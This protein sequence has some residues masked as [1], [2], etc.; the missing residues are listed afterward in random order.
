M[1]SVPLSQIIFRGL[2]LCSQSSD[3]KRATWRPLIDTATS[4][5]TISREKSS[6]TF[7]TRKRR[8]LARALSRNLLALWCVLLI[9]CAF[10]HIQVASAH[11]HDDT[12]VAAYS[13]HAHA[14]HETGTA[15]TC[16]AVQ[17]APFNQQLLTLLALT[18][19]LALAGSLGLLSDLQRRISSLQVIPLFRPGLPPPIRKQLHRYN[20]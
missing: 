9:A 14:T 16:S 12:G 1:N 2:P 6:T 17:N 13:S 11:A 18:A 10:A 19:L 8:P 15:E 4:W 20:E 5:P 3:R 7:S